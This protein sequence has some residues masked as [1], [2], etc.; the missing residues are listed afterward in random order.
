MLRPRLIPPDDI[1]PPN[2]WVL[3]ATRYDA[4]L[5]QDLTGQAETMFALSNGYLGVRGV[6]EEGTPV[7]EAGTYLNGFYEHRP[8]SYGEHA[9][10][11]PT[12]GQS[13]LNCPNGTA[14]KLF[15]DDEPF[16]VP[17]AEILSFRR[18]LDFRSGTLSRDVRWLTPAGKRLRLRTLRLV[19]LAHRHLAAIEYELTA[20][21]AVT[22]VVISSELR[23]EQPLATD[24]NDPRLAEGF[25]G[26]V[27]HPTGTRLEALRAILSYRTRSSGLALG[28]GMDH[29]VA[30]DC[31]LITQPACDDDLATVVVRGILAPGQSIRIHKF[32]SYH[33]SEA[34]S[35]EQIRALTAWTLDR[36]VESGFAAILAQQ[37]HDVERFWARADVRVDC[38]SPRT[39]QAIRWN[40]FQ[41]L[42]ASER[43]EGHGIAARGL[44]G[45]TYEGHYFWDTEIYVLPFLVYTKP[46]IA[47]SLL[48]Y[49]YDMLDKAR[50][51]ARE[52]GHRGATFPWRTINGEEASAYYA[53]GTAQYHINADIVY[54][55]RKYVEISGD[56]EFLRNYGAEILIETARLWCDLG[57]FSERLG[58]RFCINGV[59][60]PDEYTALVNNNCFTNLMARENMRYAAET[61]RRLEREHPDSF[62]VLARRTGLAATEPDAWE[63]AAERMYLPYDER[64]R[65][66]PQD[67]NFL[68][69]E[70]WDF[71]GTPEEHYPLLL[72]YHP[73]NLYRS[74]VI[75]QADTVMAM[76]L[77]GDQFTP[78]AKRRNFEYYD[79]LT[80]HDSSLSVCIQSIV[81]NEIGLREKA[82]HY[83]NF[84]L[85]MDMSDIGGNMMHGAHIAAIGGTW[86]A[87]VYGFAGLRDTQGRLTFNP[88]LPEAWARLSFTLQ[89]RGRRIGIDIDHRAATYRLLDGEAL[90]IWQGDERIDLSPDGA[91]VT[92]A[93]RI[94]A[95]KADVS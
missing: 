7:R 40:L 79:P 25:V 31:S 64:L 20:E 10:G 54:A 33:Y 76:F 46:L 44:T 51:R 94:P 74:Q 60:G 58:G 43:A 37:R 29:V 83:F 21:D 13:I 66:H 65:V 89:V 90:A 56:E 12:L 87:L 88:C 72:H 59:T 4:K 73:L 42:Q 23:N 18:S 57:F 34:A 19:S 14:V 11:F 39:Q 16:V 81:A 75:K 55:L 35:P 8:I 69:L 41:L 86:L 45:R 27:L 63:T 49:R 9:Y 2:P 17:D 6:A 22:E 95:G 47:R 93:F 50:A 30:A 71:A 78:E 26:R 91:A 1:F 28:C 52:L 48:K 3:E 36:A 92:R 68:D 5:A 80:T 62:A 70:K 15:V 84:A 38:A 82:F 61:V 32:L 24:T 85:A 67:D 77:L 53:A